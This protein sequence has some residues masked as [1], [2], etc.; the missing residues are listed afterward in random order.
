MFYDLKFSMT[1]MLSLLGLAQCVYVLVYMLFRS[2]SLANAVIPSLFFSIMATA[3]FTDFASFRLPEILGVYREAVQWGVW[4]CCLPVGALLCLQ[5]AQIRENIPLRYFLL[6]LVIPATF[7][8]GYISQDRDVLY[9]TG[10]VTGGLSLLAVWLRRD[11]LDGLY[12]NTK[13]GKERFWLIMG[14]VGLGTAFLVFTFAHMNGKIDAR[15]WLLVRTFIGIA[16][17][18]VAGTSLFR[19]YPQILK[20][21]FGQDVGGL[22]SLDEQAVLQKLKTLLDS[23][24]VYQDPTVGRVELARETGASESSLSRIVNLA[25]AKS[26]PQLLNDLRVED[27]QKLLRETDV[28][29]QNVFEE[30]GFNSVTTF[31]RV[32][33]EICGETPKEYRARHRA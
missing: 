15:E 26:I 21:D 29:I 6:L 7:S 27:A 23:E 24:K 10:M 12:I 4:F 5:L 16:F 17:A 9:A 32:F 14:L 25:Y 18:Y 13:F 11:L 22:L 31:N 33:K 19:I 8:A 1:E 2:G 20:K 28:A 30:S 3:F